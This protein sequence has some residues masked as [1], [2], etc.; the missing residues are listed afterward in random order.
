M[1]EGIKD[2]CTPLQ[3]NE[4]HAFV[5]DVPEGGLQTKAKADTDTK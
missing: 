5:G 2:I 1:E 4:F 3:L